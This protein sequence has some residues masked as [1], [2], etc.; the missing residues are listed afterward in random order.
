M[1]DVIEYVKKHWSTLLLLILLSLL[2]YYAVT[3]F[4]ELSETM[5][6]NDFEQFDLRAAELAFEMRSDLLTYFFIIVTAFG[7]WHAFVLLFII[8]TVIF[9]RHRKQYKTPLVTAGIIAG[10]GGV[11]YILKEI[12][13]RERPTLNTLVDARLSSFPSGHSMLSIVFYGFLVFFA[14]RILRSKRLKSGITLFFIVFIALICWSRVYLGAHFASD[15]VAGIIA[16]I[17][18]LSIS[19]LVYVLVKFLKVKEEEIVDQTDLEP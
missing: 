17:G 7:N 4:L 2:S 11:M 18:W 8:F 3:G 14:W 15:V 13:A 19:L 1:V 6:E 9:Y 10:A 12:F 16:G 5:V